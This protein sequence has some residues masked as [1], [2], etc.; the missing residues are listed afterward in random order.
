M[1]YATVPS[2]IIIWGPMRHKRG[3]VI[4]AHPW[5]KTCVSSETALMLTPASSRCSGMAPCR[6]YCARGGARP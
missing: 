3:H 2:V 5:R 4:T 1:L 6:F